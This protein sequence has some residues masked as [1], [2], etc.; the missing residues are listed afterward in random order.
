MC[1]GTSDGVCAYSNKSTLIVRNKLQ[2]AYRLEYLLACIN[3]RVI[4]FCFSRLASKGNQVLFPRL[5][6]TYLRSFPIRRIAFTTPPDERKRL[7]AKGQAV[8]AQ[9]CD[10]YDYDCV[11]GFVNHHLP[12]LP[13]GTPD[14]ANEHS[15]VVHDLLAFLAQRM[16]DLN[17]EH[18]AA[19]ENLVLD[20]EGV[21]S[22]G[23]LRK[24]GRLWTPPSAPDIANNDYRKKQ[25]AHE[26]ARDEAQQQL[27]RLAMRRLE[28]RE[29]I[30]AIGEEQWKWLLKRRLKKIDSMADLVRIYRKHQPGI[31]A[32]D[33]R[34]AAT[35]R[36]IDQIIYAL[37]GLSHEEVA[38]VEA[39]AQ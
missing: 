17:K 19:V 32:L 11:L 20:L 29:D 31:A 18:R 24:I 5:S 7:Q 37:Y 16:I 4:Y 23:D 21:L 38:I 22:A 36:L 30:G 12:R 35:D 34:I 33:G 3:S 28:L 15:D 26:K 27:G 2:S 6:L 25:A 39:G 9:F 13:D 8:F 1:Q 10:K 14:A